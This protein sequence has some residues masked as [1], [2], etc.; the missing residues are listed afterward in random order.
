MAQIY[1][2]SG[3]LLPE[4]PFYDVNPLIGYDSRDSPS[5]SALDSLLIT[6][7]DLQQ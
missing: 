7:R 2:P 5:I 6:G 3:M 4:T 1:V